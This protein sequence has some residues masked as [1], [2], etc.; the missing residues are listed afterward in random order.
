MNSQL[1]IH[2][3]NKLTS[4][5]Q[6]QQFHGLVF[7]RYFVAA[8]CTCETSMEININSQL[9]GT[10]KIYSVVQKR[11]TVQVNGTATEKQRG[12]MGYRNRE[13]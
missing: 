13:I 12:R 2:I 6:M 10:F 7:S 11:N 3:H 1:N 4:H 8:N 5:C 9:W